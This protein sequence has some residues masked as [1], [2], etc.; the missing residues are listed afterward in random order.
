MDTG[1][2][3][4]TDYVLS[5]GDKPKQTYLTLK[6][7]GI[8]DEYEWRNNDVEYGQQPILIERYNSGT[9]PS[10]KEIRRVGATGFE[11]GRD[12]RCDGLSVYRGDARGSGRREMGNERKTEIGSGKKEVDNS[13]AT[14][15]EAGASVKEVYDG[16]S[17]RA[18]EL[19]RQIVSGVS[20]LP[21][22][23]RLVECLGAE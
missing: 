18:K 20:A 14:D 9:W 21:R 10:E 22:K 12:Q 6:E 23:P 8:A 4:D 3:V 16:L 15:K 17:T 2:L 13:P 5:V 7:E 1:R 11:P 19:Y